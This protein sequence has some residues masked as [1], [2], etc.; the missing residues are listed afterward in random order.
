VSLYADCLLPGAARPLRIE[1]DD[2]S[3]VTA[4]H[5]DP[6]AVAGA[7]DGTGPGAVGIL[8]GGRQLA[9][10][11]GAERARAGLVV[12]TCRLP[13]VPTMRVA[14]VV[15]LGLRAP[16]PHLW[17]TII[18]TTRARQMSDD[19]EAAVRAL[20]GRMGLAGWVDAP[21]VDLP[22]VVQALAD[23]T[24]AVA[25]LPDVLV[26]RRPEWLPTPALAEITAALRDEQVRE[27]FTVVEL[28]TVGADPTGDGAT[29]AG[30]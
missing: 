17:Q 7:L 6:D 3:W 12:A 19:D 2:G 21:A 9:G 27:G 16:H 22:P 10:L 15:L 28:A 25:S 30:A 23:V 5:E 13:L 14:D 8:L 20:A 4:V 29:L 24:R 18:G 11:G 1:A 26:L